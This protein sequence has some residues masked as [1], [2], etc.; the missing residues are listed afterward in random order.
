[1]KSRDLQRHH[2]L[3]LVCKL[4]A[5]TVAM[6]WSMQIGAPHI[7]LLKTKIKIGILQSVVSAQGI[8]GRV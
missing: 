7:K 3:F 2:Y 5:L 6:T 8:D 4:A 1:M